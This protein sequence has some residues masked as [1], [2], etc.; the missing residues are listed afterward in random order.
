MTRRRF[1]WLY[2]LLGNTF[3][4]VDYYDDPLCPYVALECNECGWRAE[5]PDLDTA[6][7]RCFPDA[8]DHEHSCVARVGV[9]A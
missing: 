3:T 4:V 8:Q 2:G 9:G 5:Y 6:G 7:P 1:W